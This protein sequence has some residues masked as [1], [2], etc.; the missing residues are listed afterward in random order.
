[1]T[2][3]FRLPLFALAALLASAIVTACSDPFKVKAT[4]D[5]VEDTAAAFA[6]TG[7]PP[8]APTALNTTAGRVVR[9]EPGASFDVVFDIR[10]DSAFVI[11]AQLI[12]AFGRSFLQLGDSA[13]E[14]YTQAPINGYDSTAVLVKAG[15]V[16]L[17]KAQASIC[18]AQVISARQ[19]IYSRLV[20]DSIHYTAT[21]PHANPSPRTF[22][23]RLRTDANCGFISFH[24]GIPT[25]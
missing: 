14:S 6:F 22:Y 1:M 21:D 19:F 18:A 24:D 3:R 15:D 8:F 9:A 7:A 5:V 17:I 23:F 11:P 20:I 25:F 12:G 2:S 13:Y 4:V 16:V 10:N